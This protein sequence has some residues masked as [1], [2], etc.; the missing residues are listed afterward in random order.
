MNTSKGVGMH[1]SLTDGSV[2]DDDALDGLHVDGGAVVVLVAVLGPKVTRDNRQIVWDDAERFSAPGSTSLSPF[3][4]SRSSFSYRRKRVS[5]DDGARR[6]KSWVIR[7]HS[8]KKL[9]A[10]GKLRGRDEKRIR[11]R[12]IKSL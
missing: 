7:A 1:G 11:R 4:P 12:K 9:P 10:R 8:M 5:L 3:S 6:R 2:A